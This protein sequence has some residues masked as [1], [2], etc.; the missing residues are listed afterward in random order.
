M[1]Q[2]QCNV[3]TLIP[4]TTDLQQRYDQLKAPQ[5]TNLTYINTFIHEM[6]LFASDAEISDILCHFR[7]AVS[8]L[9]RIHVM[10]S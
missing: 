1:S 2:E 6:L 7:D 5:C 3:G 10:T 8:K 9:D 4:L